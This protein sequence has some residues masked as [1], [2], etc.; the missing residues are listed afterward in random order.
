MI[1][2]I[3]KSIGYVFV[4]NCSDKVFVEVDGF[5]RSFGWYRSPGAIV[6]VNPKIGVKTK[7]VN[8]SVAMVAV[9]V[10]IVV[11][12]DVFVEDLFV[13]VVTIAKDGVV[14]VNV[15]I[16]VVVVVVA[17]IVIVSAVVAVVKMEVDLNDSIIDVV[18]VKIS[19]ND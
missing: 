5:E 9:V 12:I 13:V 11:V 8:N 2:T 7:G 3:V 10:S 4:T 17:D 18:V 6:D 15:A 14:E 19:D 1:S 16:C